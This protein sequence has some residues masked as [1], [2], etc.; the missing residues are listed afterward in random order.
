VI[1]ATV[2]IVAVV[3]IFPL[4]GPTAGQA[5]GQ[6]GQIPRL[7]GTKVPNMGGVWQALNEA[8]WDLEAHAARAARTLHQG[9]PNGEPVPNAPELALGA[10][11][12][13]P[14][15]LGVVEGGTIPYKPELA[16]KKK[17]NF[18]H[19]LARDPEVKCLLPGVP[20]ATYLPHPFQVTQ[21]HTKVMIQYGF[22]NAGRTIHLDQVDDPGFESWM[23]HSVGRWEGDTLV[24]N[25]SDMNDQTWL[26][27]A[28]NFHSSDMKVTERYTMTSPYH[29]MY[30]AEI[31]DPTTFTRP[32]KIKMPLYKRM[33]ENARVFEFRC[34]QWTEELVYG[35]LRKSQLVRSWSDD[36]G[37]RGGT[38]GLQVTRRPTKIEE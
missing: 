3:A 12:G 14:G 17:E 4:A 16:A 27:R 38:L 1:A 2:I 35:H 21:S 24:V 31:N 36:Y 19:T 5:Q 25:V 23:G 20:R 15:S 22:S 34:I 8:N 13:I 29:I 7:A 18:D 32:W 9:V 33:E 30:E 28:G 11:A 6:A 10:T 37:R 26:D